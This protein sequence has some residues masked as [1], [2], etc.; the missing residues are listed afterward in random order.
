MTS[1]S[2][3]VFE[4]PN[5]PAPAIADLFLRDYV[6]DEMYKVTRGNTLLQNQ[7]DGTFAQVAGDAGV[8]R[9]EWAW[10]ANFVDFDNDGDLDIYC[11]NGVITGP[12]APDVCLI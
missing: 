5:F 1:N 7:G 10:G 8:E 2:R 6:R 4:D 12:E 3:W 9:A 11:P